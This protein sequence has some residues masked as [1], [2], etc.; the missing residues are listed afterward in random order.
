MRMAKNRRRTAVLFLSLFLTLN[1][2]LITSCFALDFSSAANGTTAADFL[3]LGVGAR[4]AGMGGAYNAIANDATA[5]YWN[6]AAL[7][8]IQD[9]SVSVMHAPYIASSYFDY[10]AYGQN[11]GRYGALGLSWQ[12]FSLGSIN[13]TDQTGS[14]MGSVTPYD[15]AVT[16]GYA[17]RFDDG[18]PFFLSGFSLGLAGKLIQSSIATAAQTEAA[19]IGIL[20]PGYLNRRLRLAFTADNIGEP[21]KFDQANENLPLTFN[22]GGSYQIMGNWLASLNLALPR[23]GNPYVAA[24]TEYILWRDKVWSLAGRTGYNSET[25]QSITGFTG[26]SFGFGIGYNNLAVDYAFVPFGGLGEAHRISLTIN[27]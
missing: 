23:G 27:F 25:L 19:D 26:A 17:Y 12:Y 11:L 24:G 1:F 15:M 14:N 9:K 21:L 20:S 18:A 2:E 3:N 8:T 6:P 16:V 13:Q 10:A 5:L 22:F 7:T 4:A